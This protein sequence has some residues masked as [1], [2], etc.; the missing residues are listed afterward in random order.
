MEFKDKFKIGDIIRRGGHVRAGQLMI[1]EELREPL[2]VDWVQGADEYV[3]T[4][5][6][7]FYK[8]QK[9]SAYEGGDFTLATDE[10]IIAELSRRLNTYVDIESDF[11]TIEV[12]INDEMLYVTLDEGSVLL[13]PK[14]AIQ[15]RNIINKYVGEL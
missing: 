7:L 10:D 11:G 5:T 2:G 8:P 9:W 14:A 4:C 15:L 3:Y 6:D 13:D 12:D 1:V